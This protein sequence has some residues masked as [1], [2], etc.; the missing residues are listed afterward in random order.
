MAFDDLSGDED[1]GEEKKTNNNKHN[2]KQYESKN[3]V[4]SE[5]LA[6]KRK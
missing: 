1:G 4:D 2:H 6:N 5:K 3:K